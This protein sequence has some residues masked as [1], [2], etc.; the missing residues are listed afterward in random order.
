MTA[1]PVTGHYYEV[2]SSDPSRAQVWAYT[3]ALSYA[4]GDEVVLHGMSSAAVAHVEITRD[5]LVPE[6]VLSA[7]SP[8]SLPRRRMIVR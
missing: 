4:A 7:T 2:A 1:M 3:S 6:V 5:G 8:C